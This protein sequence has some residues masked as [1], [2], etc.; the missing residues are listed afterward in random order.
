MYCSRIKCARLEQHFMCIIIVG[1]V[2]E[3]IER[4]RDLPKIRVQLHVQPPKDKLF[5]NFYF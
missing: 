1:G 4:V 2:A 5:V 3:W